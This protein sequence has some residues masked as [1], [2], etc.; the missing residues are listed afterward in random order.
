MR[1]CEYGNYDALK[2][3]ISYGANLEEKFD[4]TGMTALLI[5][6]LIGR[7]ECAKLLIENGANVDATDKESRTALILAAIEGNAEIISLLIENKANVNGGRQDT[8][9]MTA[10]SYGQTECAKLLLA[11]ESIEVDAMN[12][13]GDTALSCAARMGHPDVISLLKL[14]ANVNI[15]GRLGPTAREGMVCF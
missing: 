3:I 8:A 10:A 12:D 5:C 4:S 1:A 2:I 7:L 9:L 13:N 11:V 14:K 15:V 6:A